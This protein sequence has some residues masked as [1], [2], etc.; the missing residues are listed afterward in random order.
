[1]SPDANRHSPIIVGAS[2]AHRIFVWD[3]QT[4][5]QLPDINWYARSIAL[6][7]D[8]TRLAAAGTSLVT[9]W[10]TSDFAP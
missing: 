4:G 1:M 2:F 3:A 10:D 9:I 7:P 5:E 6:S 8:G